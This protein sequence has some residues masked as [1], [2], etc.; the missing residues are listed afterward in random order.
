M[1]LSLVE[2]QLRIGHKHFLLFCVQMF[3]MMDCVP[4]LVKWCQQWGKK[5]LPP[6][7]KSHC[8]ALQ[9]GLP[10][11]PWWYTKTVWWILTMTSYPGAG[12]H[13]CRIHNQERRCLPYSFFL[14]S[15]LSLGFSATVSL[16]IFFSLSLYECGPS[17][18]W[19]RTGDGI[20][21]LSWPETAQAAHAAM[22][23]S[24]VGGQS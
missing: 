7:T 15:V 19:G 13:F 9:K 1:K 22:P 6:L 4:P 14:L 16:E 2:C 21:L 8:L 12:T 24:W 17:T 3:Y 20:H 18:W 10:A 23:V 5:S 11:N